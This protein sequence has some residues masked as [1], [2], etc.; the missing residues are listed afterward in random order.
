VASVAKTFTLYTPFKCKCFILWCLPVQDLRN[1]NKFNSIQ[2]KQQNTTKGF[3]TIELLN[4]E[5]PVWKKC[6]FILSTLTD[7]GNLVQY[8]K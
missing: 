3:N 1:V 2:F 8:V 7:L 4:F 5:V 6:K